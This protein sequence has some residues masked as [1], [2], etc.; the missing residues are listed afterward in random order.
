MPEV[1]QVGRLCES[2]WKR[3]NLEALHGQVVHSAE[4]LRDF[5]CLLRQKCRKGLCL[6][7]ITAVLKVR[8]EQSHSISCEESALSSEMQI[9]PRLKKSP[10]YFSSV[11]L[12]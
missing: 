5:S 10:I 2:S 12:L 8:Q 1:I 4:D 6:R 3:T 9:F 11:I 7:S